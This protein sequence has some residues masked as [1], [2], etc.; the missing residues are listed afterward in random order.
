MRNELTLFVKES[1]QQGQSRAAITDAL[2]SAGWQKQ[3]I[4]KA[5]NSFADIDFAVPIP[6]PK[7]YLAAREAFL[8]L[9]SFITLYISA[10]S[11]G[12]LLFQ[13][14][15]RWF[16]DPSRLAYGDV[17]FSSLRMAIAS[18]IIAFPL[19]LALM[20]KLTKS[21]AQD[22]ERS[23]SLVRKWLTYLTLVV[24]AGVLIGDSISLLFNVLGGETTWRFFLKSLVV[25][26]IGGAILGF[27]LTGLQKE[28]KES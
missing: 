23:Q 14:I 4:A 19:H 1:L 11:F 27:Y 15:D 3:E 9:L 20:A 18:L 5:M 8:Y 2:L 6:K 26:L 24:V 28:E 22:P 16:P 17:S 10:F 7:P 21:A 13:F 25:F 12:A